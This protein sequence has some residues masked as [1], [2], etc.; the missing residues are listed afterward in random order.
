M[1]VT[2]FGLLVLNKCLLNTTCFVS[3]KITSLLIIVKYI[4]FD[5]I[6]D[7]FYSYFK[8]RLCK[9]ENE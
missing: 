3:I 6:V 2:G 1:C 9:F 8:Y 5:I 7:N 4:E